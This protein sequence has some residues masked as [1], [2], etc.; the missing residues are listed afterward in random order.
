MLVSSDIL[1]FVDHTL[2][3]L[4]ERQSYHLRGFPDAPRLPAITR[5]SERSYTSVAGPWGGPYRLYPFVEAPV[6]EVPLRW[7]GPLLSVLRQRAGFSEGE[8]W[9]ALADE[10]ESVFAIHGFEERSGLPYC[11][12][13]TELSLLTLAGLPCGS[14]NVDYPRLKPLDGMLPESLWERVPE[15]MNR[16][17]E[18]LWMGLVTR[19]EDLSF[20]R[21]CYYNF[22]PEQGERGLPFQPGH[23]GF[24]GAAVTLCGLWLDWTRRT[25]NPRGAEWARRM[26]DKF[27]AA[28]H[29]E[30]G[31]L[32]HMFYTADPGSPT[33]DPYL[34]AHVYDTD[35]AVAWLRQLDLRRELGLDQKAYEDQ[36]RIHRQNL[37]S[38]ARLA[39]DSAPGSYH[40]WINLDG[41]REVGQV[42]YAFPTEEVKREAVAQDPKCEAVGVFESYGCYVDG[43]WSYGVHGFGMSLPLALSEGAALLKD[44]EVFA[45]LQPYLDQ[46]REEFSQLSGAINEANQYVCSANACHIRTFLNAYAGRRDP[47][48]LKTACE[49]AQWEIEHLL[50]LTS[51]EEWE[52]APNLP[53]WWRLHLR[54]QVLDALL[55][56][57]R[58]LS[59]PQ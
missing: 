49:I 1:A 52:S 2:R 25:G 40:Q 18:S 42:R 51:G 16:A 22:S 11:G 17:M 58:A 56:L 3:V 37:L 28:R 50:P 36:R 54:S 47:E 9:G 8:K 48:D 26:T 10:M 27:L 46:I 38:M 15:K 32:P 12:W 53:A 33:Q 21:F 55:Q 59:H 39:G 30:T 57:A 23:C 19:E 35:N 29:S 24:Q 5:R 14:E 31:L 45:A 6:Q 13:E 41:S 44:E 43:P 4:Q 7:D 34:M 20:N